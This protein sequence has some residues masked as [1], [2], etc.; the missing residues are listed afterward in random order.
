MTTRREK[1]HPTMAAFGF[2]YAIAAMLGVVVLSPMARADSATIAAGRV[3]AAQGVVAGRPGCSSCHMQNGAG[4]PDVGI[5]RLAGLTAPV[6]MA[7][8]TYFATGARHDPAMSPAASLLTEGQR[9]EA[10]DYFA[11]LP[12]PTQ[13]DPL[14]ITEALRIRGRSLFLDG[15]QRT[16]LI[17]CAQCHGATALGVGAFSPSLAGQSAAYVAE[18]LDHWR[19]GAIRDPQGAFMRA[20]ARNL[21]HDDINA[22][23]AF[24]A[25]LGQT[26]APKP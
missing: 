18:Q 10:A 20:E 5:P 4:Q 7:Q 15:D 17:A 3:I 13:T 2:A 14:P 16:G 11:S 1:A 22:V 12:V 6:I 26:E 9:Q 24:V 8:L 25:S 23:A 21:T 19:G